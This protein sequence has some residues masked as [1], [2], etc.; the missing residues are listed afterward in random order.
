M[1][2]KNETSRAT[3]TDRRVWHDTFYVGSAEV[4]M[5]AEKF[6][7]CPLLDTSVYI[8]GHLC[9]IT[10]PKKDEFLEKLNELIAEYS[11]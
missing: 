9:C 10:H 7:D 1:P 4:T 11:I 2:W 8:S 5:E 6:P 3:G